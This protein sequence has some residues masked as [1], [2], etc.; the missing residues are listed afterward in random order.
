MLNRIFIYRG[1]MASDTRVNQL[2]LNLRNEK[3]DQSS[4]RGGNDN[5][6]QERLAAITGLASIEIRARVL[7]VSR[8]NVS[9]INRAEPFARSSL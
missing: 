9:R 2:P 3:H 1:S 4:M 8:L 6:Y 7:L 5:T